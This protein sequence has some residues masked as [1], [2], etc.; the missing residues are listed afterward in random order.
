MLIGILRALRDI[1]L[2]QVTAVANPTDSRQIH[3]LFPALQS[4]YDRNHDDDVSTPCSTTHQ[5]SKEYCISDYELTSARRMPRLKLEAPNRMTRKSILLSLGIANFEEKLKDLNHRKVFYRDDVQVKSIH[6][7][8][9]SK[10]LKI[11][12]LI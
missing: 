10:R 12:R 5:F 11:V 7:T 2:L 9:K 6:Y 8:Y 1:P 3:L 4:D